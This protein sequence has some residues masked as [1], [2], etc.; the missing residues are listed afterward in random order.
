METYRANAIAVEECIGL[1]S[2]MEDGGAKMPEE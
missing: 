1:I 2:P